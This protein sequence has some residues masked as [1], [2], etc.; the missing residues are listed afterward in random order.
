MTGEQTNVTNASTVLPVRSSAASPAEFAPFNITDQSSLLGWNIGTYVQDEWKLT[1]QLTLNTGLRFDQLYQFVDANQLSPR[2]ALVYKPFVGT[3][4]PCRLR[5]LFHAALSSAGDPIQHR[6]VRQYDATS[7]TDSIADPVK[8]ER[9]HYFD[10]G[11]DQT[12][13]PGLTIGLD[14]YYKMAR[15]MI[16]DGQFGAAVVLTQFNWE[17]GY[18]EGGEFKLKYNNGNFNAYANFSYNITRAINAEFEPVS[19]RCRHARVSTACLSLHRRHAAHDRLG[20]RIL[21]LVRYAVHC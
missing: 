18:S 5:A 2:F 15:D 17:R 19:I 7:R 11:V 4:I 9:S 14:A 1:N 3:T 16:D 20:R 12:V 13:L 10:V 8:P 21:S 6:A